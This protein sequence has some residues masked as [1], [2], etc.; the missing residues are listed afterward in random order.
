MEIKAGETK[1]IHTVK[2]GEVKVWNFKDKEIHFTWG[3]YQDKGFINLVSGVSTVPQNVLDAV[4]E[5]A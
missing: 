2:F 1:T 5:A 3:K 4:G